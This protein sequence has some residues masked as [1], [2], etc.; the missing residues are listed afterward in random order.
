[1]EAAVAHGTVECCVPRREFPHLVDDKLLCK[2]G[3]GEALSAPRR[4]CTFEQLRR[5]NSCG[6]V[7]LDG[8]RQGF[9]NALAREAF[10]LAAPHTV[11]RRLR[12]GG[13]EYEVHAWDAALARRTRERGGAVSREFRGLSLRGLGAELQCLE[14]PECIARF[15]VTA[16]QW[17]E[18]MALDFVLQND[19][20]FD[21]ARCGVSHPL[22][23]VHSASSASDRTPAWFREKFR[24]ERCAT[25][26]TLRG[27]TG[28]IHIFR[29]ASGGITVIDTTFVGGAARPFHQLNWNPV[30]LLY[31]APTT[32]LT[33]VHALPPEPPTWARAAGMDEEYIREVS[34][35]KERASMVQHYAAFVDLLRS[36]SLQSIVEEFVEG[37]VVVF[38]AAPWSDAREL[39]EDQKRAEMGAVRRARLVGIEDHLDES[40]GMLKATTE[41]SKFLGAEHRPLHAEAYQE[42]MRR[43]VAQRA[44]CRALDM[45]GDALKTP[46][47][48]WDGTGTP[49][50]PPQPRPSLARL[51]LGRQCQHECADACWEHRSP[52]STCNVSCGHKCARSCCAWWSH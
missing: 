45:C 27:D 10:G 48:S 9:A 17:H 33:R 47:E 31:A 23:N 19:D 6:L 12:P 32:V 20:R 42:A 24:A 4:A 41:F 13:R 37:A 18:V 1:M 5:S 36:G 39:T 21:S 8:R 40:E 30:W 14:L 29:N 11:V 49:T 3:V 52:W 15:G 35:I 44:A 46:W 22:F 16:N 2:F 26:G 34:T 51:P 50:V 38:R 25:H 28:V 7:F 43:F